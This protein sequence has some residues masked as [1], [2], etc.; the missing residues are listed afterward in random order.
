MDARMTLPEFLS[1]GTDR[2]YRALAT[3]L[4]DRLSNQFVFEYLRTLAEQGE[5]A[6]S[7]NH[8]VQNFHFRRGQLMNLT[9]TDARQTTAYYRP[10][11][12]VIRTDTH[13]VNRRGL[14]LR[15]SHL[16]C[17]SMAGGYIHSLLR[18][19]VFRR[20]EDRF[21]IELLEVRERRP[22]AFA[23]YAHRWGPPPEQQRTEVGS[24]AGSEAEPPQP[25]VQQ[26]AEQP[27]PREQER[28]GPEEAGK[29]L[30]ETDETWQ[31]DNNGGW[32][33]VPVPGFTDWVETPQPDRVETPQSPERED[34]SEV[35]NGSRMFPQ[36]PRPV[37]KNKID[38]CNRM[39]PVD[40][41][42]PAKQKGQNQ[43][44]GSPPR[45]SGKGFGAPSQQP[46][47]TSDPPQT[48]SPRPQTSRRAALRE[49]L[50]SEQAG[51]LMQICDL[52]KGLRLD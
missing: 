51:I 52:L 8:L 18:D 3:L 25:E 16:P 30:T 34:K 47:A 1:N 21:P 5:I 50:D 6:L 32:D 42:H 38:E 2:E 49:R 44:R 7:T 39:N 40:P 27:Q 43:R 17:L 37:P 28:D 12:G 4:G 45:F 29:Q 41:K 11:V 33:E 10:R 46:T 20:H 26:Q 13:Q 19:D 9:I 22:G 14:R 36:N 48:I 24:Q 31:P 35:Q 15:Y 23:R